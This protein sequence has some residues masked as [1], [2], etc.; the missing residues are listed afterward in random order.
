MSL[1]EACKHVAYVAVSLTLPAASEHSDAQHSTMTKPSM[2][3]CIVIDFKR[4]LSCSCL[5]S[6]RGNIPSVPYFCQDALSAFA[7]CF[8]DYAVYIG[9]VSDTMSAAEHAG[10]AEESGF[11]GGPSAQEG[12]GR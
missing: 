11:P 2:H 4:K 7:S 5:S 9:H 3:A 1:S 8:T 6:S 10:H 12:S